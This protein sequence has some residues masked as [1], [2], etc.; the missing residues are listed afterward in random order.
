MAS[1]SDVD[2]EPTRRRGEKRLLPSLVVVILIAIPFLL[3]VHQV[4]WAPWVL[5]AI[6]VPLLIGIVLADPGRID[7][8]SGTLRAV[9]IGLIGLLLVAA[10]GATVRL[11][12]ELI[13]GVPEMRNAPVLLRT[14]FLVWIDASLS[15]ALLYWELDSG[16]PAA[17]LLDP[18]PH[19]DIAFPQQLSP[20]VAAPGWMPTMIDYLYLGLT[21]ALAFSPTDAMPLSHWAKIA[22]A[23][24]S[25]ISVV[26]LS[27]VI[28]NAVNVLG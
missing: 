5:A 11:V 4:G 26:I 28:A 10:G 16:G 3:P 8:R 15:F 1:P 9:S 18:V 17:R 20:E 13:Q 2:L 22:M 24:Q 23:T 6:A 27:L 25:I 21:N 14:G 12:L 19:P 7:E